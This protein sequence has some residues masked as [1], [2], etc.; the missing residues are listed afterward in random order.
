MLFIRFSIGRHCWS[1]N[2]R[3]VLGSNCFFGVATPPPPL[4]LHN[5][6]PGMDFNLPAAEVVFRTQPSSLPATSIRTSSRVPTKS[7]SANIYTSPSCLLNFHQYYYTSPP[8]SQRLPTSANILRHRW[9]P[10]GQT[11]TRTPFPHEF[12]LSM[13]LSDIFI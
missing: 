9:Q 11:H 8:R 1:A 4:W 3:Y 5:L 6:A 12:R 2:L 10:F 13:P 7:C